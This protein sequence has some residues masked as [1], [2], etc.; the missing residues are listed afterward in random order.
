MTISDWETSLKYQKSQSNQLVFALTVVMKLQHFKNW[1]EFW[2]A[3]V[4]PQREDHEQE[5]WLTNGSVDVRGRPVLRIKSGGWKAAIFIMVLEF[6]DG[7]TSLALQS[8]LIIYLTTVLH[9]GVAESVKNIN[10]WT[11]VTAAVYLTGAFI[12]DAYCGGYWM[13]F[14]SS[15]IYLLGLLSLTLSVSLSALKP[16]DQCD[17]SV[18]SKAT[19][20]Q[21]GVFFLALYLVCLG[22]G[23]VKP[24][25]EAF[26]ADQFDEEDKTEM[27]KKNSFFNVWFFVL[28]SSIL[29]A[30]TFVPYI[31]ENIS[32]GFGFG[33]LTV[34]MAIGTVV[35]L[36]GTPFYR[37]RPPR[38]SQVSRIAQVVIAATR[39]IN[40]S[41]PSDVNLLYEDMESIKSSQRLLSRTQNFQ[42]L[43]K[44]AIVEQD[45][46]EWKIDKRG[47]RKP[48]PWKLC[49]VTQVEET[50][51]ILRVVPIWICCFMFGMALTQ[52]MSLFVKQGSTMDRRLG[53]HFIVPS[54]SLVGLGNIGGLVFVTLYDRCMVP[55]ARRITGNERGITVLQRIGI[56]MF[57]SVMCMITA[58]LTEKKRVHVARTHGLLD[59][60]RSVIPL[61]V[62]YLAPQFLLMGIAGVF[63]L[64][65][66]QEYFYGQV[67]DSMRN[68]GIALSE[69]VLGVS[70]FLGSLVITIVQK[71]TKGRWFVN[72]LNRSKLDYFYWLLA[73][74]GAINL[75]FYVYITRI[76]TYKKV[77]KQIISDTSSSP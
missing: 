64:V 22:T 41:M 34:A 39:K 4:Q 57:L 26:G 40:K 38:G 54:A 8:N 25:L 73:I 62:F 19:S 68:L 1:M 2:K 47:N 69:S 28:S 50:K 52:S 74:L 10:Y 61:S 58:A 16:P 24:S 35:F 42:F 76:Y 23:G 46:S 11:G 55:L 48:N 21:I 31:Q 36:Y 70:S 43:D 30:V 5:E 9:E 12:A 66:M 51:L 72:N 71:A 53:S 13:V 7:L 59:N 49:T 18:C 77:V 3:S 60:P 44:A 29:L 75:C 27:A 65:G 56:G 67:P 6:T 37:H 32:W 20:T 63:T 17:D 33:I 15:I 45:S 14:M